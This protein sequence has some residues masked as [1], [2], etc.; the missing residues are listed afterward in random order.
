LVF[1]NRV[2]DSRYVYHIV[3]LWSPYRQHNTMHVK[4]NFR[5]FVGVGN[6][7]LWAVNGTVQSFGAALRT[8]E[9]FAL[10]SNVNSIVN[11]RVERPCGINGRD[12]KGGA[13]GTVE[14]FVS[15]SWRIYLAQV[16]AKFSPCSSTVR[17][18]DT[19]PHYLK[20]NEYKCD[21][22]AVSVKTVQL[23]DNNKQIRTTQVKQISTFQL[24]CT[25]LQT[26]CNMHSRNQICIYRVN[27]LAHYVT[28]KY[29]RIILSHNQHHNKY[30][31]K[32]H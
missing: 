25:P 10:P 27:Q 31:H 1:A 20:R 18:V 29:R 6:G 32:T 13:A 3:C 16:I 15:R 8:S 5:S 19:A 7:A 26:M 12:G 24:Q 21:T 28:P 30:T 22:N 17:T 4:P 23:S 9:V 11:N 2:A 14:C